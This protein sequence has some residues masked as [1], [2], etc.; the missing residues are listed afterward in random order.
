MRAARKNASVGDQPLVLGVDVGGT[1]VAAA[2]VAGM[3]LSAA[4]KN[5]TDVSSSDALLEGIESTVRE[6]IDQ[7]GEPAGI[8]LGMPSQIEFATGTV[9]TSVNIP[10][11]GV[12]LREELGRRLGVPVFIDN[13]A[14]CAALAEAEC[15]GARHLVMLT[16]GTG[17]GGGVVIDGRIFRGAHGLG[18]E[19]GHFPIEANGPP[20]PGTCPNR[21]CVEA[22]CSGTALERDAT[23]LGQARPDTPLGR[24]VSAE[25]KCGGKAAVEAARSGDRD[26]VEL[27]DRLGT[28]LG[29]AIAG[30]VN[31]FQPEHFV[32]GGGLS[33]AADQ[34][35]DRAVEEARSRALPALWDRV[36]V[37]LA[38]SGENAGLIGAGLLA[39]H[40]IDGR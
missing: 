2:G 28:A 20:C 5:P 7:V 34:F 26:A 1:K 24:V 13:D 16:L 10:L 37:G 3:E 14:N 40:E 18:A 12:P 6:V 33:A 39:A 32:V 23:Q 19:L 31:V 30:Y 36:E 11:T 8:G 35:L 29:I 17:V 9:L 15:V 25:G 4:A 22:F 38:K 27:L 21:G